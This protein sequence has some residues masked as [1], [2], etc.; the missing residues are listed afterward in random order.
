MALTPEDILAKR[1][2][3]TKFREGYDQDEVDDYLDEVVVELRKIIAENE[4]LKTRSVAGVEGEA[5]DMPAFPVAVDPVPAPA[6]EDTDASRSIIELAQKLHADHVHEGKV[7]R[8]QLI[9][10]AQ[11]EA[12]RLVRDAEAQAREILNQMELDRRSIESSI[13]D[14]KRF[15]SEYRSKLRDYIQEQLSQILTEEAFGDI[16][17]EVEPAENSEVEFEY[18]DQEPAPIGSPVPAA[19]A[20]DE[21]EDEE[22]EDDEELESEEDEVEG[23]SKR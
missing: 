23:E 14:L 12:A 18:Y 22:L 4:E 21:A 8:E 11:R 13:E 16:S 3:I 19:P 9:R 6:A 7:K 20:E 17:G 5:A 15:E 2:Q 1:F 10:D